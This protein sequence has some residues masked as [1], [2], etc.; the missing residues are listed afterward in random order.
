MKIFKLIKK[1]EEE[2]FKN[3]NQHLIVST[4]LTSDP[5]GFIYTSVLPCS[6]GHLK[7]IP[8]SLSFYP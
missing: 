4:L 7:Q 1:R 8:S 2:E 5:S 3:S 6:L